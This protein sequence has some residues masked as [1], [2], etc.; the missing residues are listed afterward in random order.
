MWGN[1]AIQLNGFE[2]LMQI[3]QQISSQLLGNDVDVAEVAFFMDIKTPNS[4]AHCE[5]LLSLFLQVGTEL[6]AKARKL[7]CFVSLFFKM[8]GVPS[9]LYH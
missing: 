8:L 7:N 2:E 1:A 9:Q 6:Q 3:S 5:K 4:R